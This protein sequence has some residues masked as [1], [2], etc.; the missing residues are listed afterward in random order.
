MFE[1]VS[2]LC[3]AVLTEA[4]RGLRSPENGVTEA[5]FECWE[6]NPSPP[7]DYSVL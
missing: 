6:S 1:Y 3:I 5:R 7:E 2:A 4:K